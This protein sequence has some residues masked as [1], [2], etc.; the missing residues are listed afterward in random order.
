MNGSA[1]VT[2]IE[3]LSELR[4]ALCTFGEK[5]AEALATA[6]AE[7]RRTVD[8]LED[9]YK[10]WTHEVRRC[11][12]W[13][14][15]ARTELNRRR[16]LKIGDRPPDCTEQEEELQKARMALEHAEDQVQRTR[17]WERLWQEAIIEYRGPVGQLKTLLDGDLPKATALL[18][19][20][21]TALD[22]YV[23]LAAP[24]T[25]APAAPKPERPQS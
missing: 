17:R 8:W 16:M 6:D 11:E 15:Q 9:Q 7:I 21:I 19:R 25:P 20:K 10:Y 18:E 22:E 5:S 4:A 2:A 12:D 23:S 1:N 13:V 3:A 24:V 14:F